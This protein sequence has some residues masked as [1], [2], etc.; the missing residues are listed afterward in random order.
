MVE[1]IHERIDLRAEKTGRYIKMYEGKTNPDTYTLIQCQEF[2]AAPEFI[3]N[4]DHKFMRQANKL[5]RLDL[6]CSSSGKKFKESQAKAELGPDERSTRKKVLRSILERYTSLP[7][8][9][10]LINIEEDLTWVQFCEW[11]SRR[12][13]EKQVRA[14]ELFSWISRTFSS[15]HRAY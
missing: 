4:R 14:H 2:C 10:E 9:E 8:I 15:F 7:T 3:F 12:A 13:E 1:F 11:Y 5:L 6:L